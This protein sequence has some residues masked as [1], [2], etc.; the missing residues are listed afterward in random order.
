MNPESIITAFMPLDELRNPNR[1]RPKNNFKK[2]LCFFL[3]EHGMKDWQIANV[4]GRKRCDAL[5]HRHKFMALYHQPC[6]T[7][8]RNYYRQILALYEA[9]NL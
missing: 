8:V 5:H 9:Q 6:E 4:I 1:N 7:E 2:A 3:W